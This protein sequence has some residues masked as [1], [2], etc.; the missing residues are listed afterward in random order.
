[1]DKYELFL[2]KKNKIILISQKPHNTKEEL[3]KIAGTDK[4][5]ICD[6]YVEGAEN[7]NYQNNILKE[8][9]FIN[10]DHH[11]PITQLRKHISSGNIA[12]KYVQKYNILDDDYFVIVNHLDCDS[13]ISSFIM[14]GILEPTQELMRS[15]IAADH[16]GEENQISD[17]LQS[18]EHTR[19]IDF[20]ANNL[21][22][23][24]KGQKLENEAIQMMAIRRKNRERIDSMIKSNKYQKEGKIS[25]FITDSNLDPTLLVSLLPQSKAIMVSSKSKKDVNKWIHRIR[26][27]MNEENKSL[28]EIDLPDFGGRWN[29]GSTRRHGG[30]LIEPKEYARILNNKLKE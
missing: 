25:Y 4:I 5:C 15:V 16:T 30:T 28:K 18:V 27:G 21:F 9:N 23:L 1:M 19:N 26:L 14:L 8:G 12:K 6:F 22:K 17:L 10:I 11:S 2:K 20:I 24:M 13:I 29:A 3:E 7:W